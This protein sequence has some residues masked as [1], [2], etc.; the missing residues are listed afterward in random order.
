MPPPDPA[1]AT[2]FRPY[3]CTKHIV[4]RGRYVTSSDPRGY[5][6]VYEYPL[7]GQW[8]M[9]DADNGYVLWTGIW[10]GTCNRLGARSADRLAQR[11]ERTRVGE[12]GSW[13]HLY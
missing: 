6:P 8:L 3:A 2:H 7:N 10:K 12:G 4:T 9:V 11:W 13:D 5:L 1:H